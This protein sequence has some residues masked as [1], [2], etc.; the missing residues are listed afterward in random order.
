[1]HNLLSK[2]IQ[3]ERAKKKGNERFGKKRLKTYPARN[4][5]VLTMFDGIRTS[6]FL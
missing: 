6:P 4:K 5:N 3:K 1:M 2:T